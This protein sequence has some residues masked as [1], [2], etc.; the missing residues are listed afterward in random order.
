ML[1]KI[2]KMTLSDQKVTYPCVICNKLYASKRSLWN[3]NKKYHS[4]LV[5]NDSPKSKHKVSIGKP[6]VSSIYL[7]KF[8]NKEYLHKQSKYR[9]EKSCKQKDEIPITID[10]SITN[11]NSNNTITQNNTQNIVINNFGY[12]DITHLTDSQIRNMILS[13]Y[14][15]DVEYLHKVHLNKDIPQNHNILCNNIQGK[16]IK[17]YRDSQWILELATDIIESVI[18][19]C[20]SLLTIK[21]KEFQ[22]SGYM[23]SWKPFDNALYDQKCNQVSVY[24]NR[25]NKLKLYLYN[26]KDLIKYK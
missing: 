4:T 9:H 20:Y 21:Y 6:N 1:K 25:F 16:Y 17:V 22:A 8:C 19:N 7:C 13:G 12:E 24:T 14:E 11:I 5:S 3:H 26:A 15:C 18:C 23:N 2:E 10:N